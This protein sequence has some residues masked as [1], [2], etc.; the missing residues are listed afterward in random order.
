V[1]S[2]PS[3]ELANA[4]RAHVHTLLEED[5]SKLPETDDEAL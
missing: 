1:G 3:P 5:L 2:F 4:A